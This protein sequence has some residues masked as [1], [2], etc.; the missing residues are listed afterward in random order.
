VLG[1]AVALFAVPG[2]RLLRVR[3]RH[4]PRL[5]IFEALAG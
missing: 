2:G 3:D 4:D 1:P 5:P